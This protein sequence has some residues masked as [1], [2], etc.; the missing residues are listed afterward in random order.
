LCRD[1]GG[2]KF[3]QHDVRK[4]RCITCSPDS[5]YFCKSCK[6]FGVS[7]RTNHLCSYCNPD[8]TV[9]R[10]TKENRVRDLLL[11]HNIPFVQDK[12]VQNDCCVKYRPDFLI[13]YSNYC[14]IV[15]CEL[16]IR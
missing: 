1:C 14:I 13:E 11:K 12:V 16:S 10:K 6:L 8:K 3:C 9:R 5:N 4:E 2:S 15:E 7:K